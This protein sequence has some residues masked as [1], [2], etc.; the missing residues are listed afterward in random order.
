[1]KLSIIPTTGI[2]LVAATSFFLLPQNA[3]AKQWDMCSWEEIPHHVIKRIAKRPDYPEIVSRMYDSCPEAALALTDPATSS[4]TVYLPNRADLQE[5]I[6]N[7]TSQDLDLETDTAS[8]GSSSSDTSVNDSGGS[9][10][11]E[12]DTGGSSS[13]GGGDSSG[14]S[15]GDGTSESGGSDGG[16]SSGSRGSD[17]NNGGG[18]GSEGGSPG[19]ARGANDDE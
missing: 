18:N 8:L 11:G 2:G 15:G 7:E 19:K 6:M 3:D 5:E 16:D 9:S 17:S 4:I 10:T 14:N 12:S 1:M 13:D